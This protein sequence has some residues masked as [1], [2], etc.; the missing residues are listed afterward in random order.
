[1]RHP[2]FAY[3]TELPSF[4]DWLVCVSLFEELLVSMEFETE[5]CSLVVFLVSVELAVDR[6]LP[7]VD[8]ASEEVV[9]EIES[10]MSAPDRDDKDEV[11]DFEFKVLAMAFNRCSSRKSRMCSP[12]QY[13]SWWNCSSR[14]VCLRQ[15]NFQCWFP[16]WSSCR[17]LCRCLCLIPSLS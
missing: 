2:M 4:V 13:Y 3:C 16:R 17:C 11:V 10:A 1:M 14:F 6:W 15:M 8:L 5:F 12:D 9:V 7:V